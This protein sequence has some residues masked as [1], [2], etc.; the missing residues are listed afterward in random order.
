[1]QSRQHFE[2]YFWMHVE[3]V[4]KPVLEQAN[5]Q[6]FW[7]LAHVLVEKAQNDSQAITLATKNDLYLA[8]EGRRFD[9]QLHPPQP[10]A[11]A[12]F[13][14]AQQEIFVM[15]RSSWFDRF[16]K[17]NLYKVA[18]KDSLIQLQRDDSK[19]DS[20]PK[21]LSR[22]FS[23][24]EYF[25]ANTIPG[26]ERDDDGDNSLDEEQDEHSGNAG[27]SNSINSSSDLVKRI[28]PTKKALSTEARRP[29]TDRLDR[30]G[31]GSEDDASDFSSD[32]SEEAGDKVVLNLESIIRLTKLPDGLQVH[33]RPNYDM[34]VNSDGSE[35]DG[36]LDWIVTFATFVE[37]Q[38]G[39]E[40]AATLMLMPV[41]NPNQPSVDSFDDISRRIKMFLVPDDRVLIKRAGAS[42]PGPGDMLF[43]FQQSGPNGFLFGSVF[44]TYEPVRVGTSNEEFFTAKGFCLLSRLPLVNSLRVLVEHHVTSAKEQA[45]IFDCDRLKTLFQADFAAL[46]SS[47]GVAND[48]NSSDPQQH[49]LRNAAKHSSVLGLPLNALNATVDVSVTRVFDHLGTALTLQ[50]LASALLESSVVF[51]SRQYSLLTA[52]AEAVRNL[53]RPFSW[54]HV[55][56]PVLP[57]P[58]LSY[59][60]CPTP[61]LV[62]I[63]SDYAHRSDMP[64]KG[65]YLIADLDRHVVEY[66]GNHSVGWKSLG[67]VDDGHNEVK[68]QNEQIYLPACFEA[69]KHRLD[70]ILTPQ[71]D[72]YDSIGGFVGMAARQRRSSRPSNSSIDDQVRV[73]CLD[74]FSELLHGHSSACLV[75]G[76]TKES[77]V[78]FDET[79]F[80]STRN[81]QDLPFYRA[82]MRT[83]CF[84]EIVSAHR[85]NLSVKEHDFEE[86]EVDDPGDLQ[87][88]II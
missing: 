45:D 11:K 8:I 52:C 10:V 72:Q 39:E 12:L 88:G 4:L 55:Y 9:E 58:L 80:L 63:H 13:S 44:L 24:A 17:S 68:S 19:E 49:S 32:D 5:Y 18:L 14:R 3:Y 33:Y 21:L 87:E 41:S 34:A 62:G 1:M 79:Q 61:I 31:D 83:Q 15:L 57:K 20:P 81:E 84:S 47:G 51:V 77:V 30:D 78:I 6:L 27:T 48:A 59:L 28:I 43:P 69:A 50:V 26:S 53:L 71:D 65:F 74:L 22:A 70:K 73:V 7:R 16:M 76:D 38:T 82:L 42:D 36:A 64:N 40:A 56:A 37:K 66:V 35:L 54:C 86:L 29:T 75:V 85:I 60:Q 67:L 2:L 25:A 46:R 23:S